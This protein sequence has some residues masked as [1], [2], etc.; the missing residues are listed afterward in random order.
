MGTSSS[1]ALACAVAQSKSWMTLLFTLYVTQTEHITAV[2]GEEG[3]FT[4]SILILLGGLVELINELN[5]A[6][7]HVGYYTDMWNL[8]DIIAAITCD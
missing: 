7:G 6:K 4:M 8:A 1:Q 3:T 2:V 5:E